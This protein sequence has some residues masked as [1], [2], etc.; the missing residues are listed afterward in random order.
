MIYVYGVSSFSTHVTNSKAG[1]NKHESRRRVLPTQ[2]RLGHAL[3]YWRQKPET[4]PGEDLRSE[5][6]TYTLKLST[7]V[8]L[9][10]N[11]SYFLKARYNLILYRKRR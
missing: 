2:P 9:R 1:I 11:I 7:L 8:A 4:S 3:T 5:V 10:M 6:E